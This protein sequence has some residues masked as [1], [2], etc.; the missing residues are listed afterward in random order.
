MGDLD[1][2]VEVDEG[3]GELEGEPLDLGA[4][5]WASV[6]QAHKPE[7]I[8]PSHTASDILSVC[9]STRLKAA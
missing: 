9:N 1:L 8:S 5:Q 7:Q 2:V 6:M 3:V 4:R